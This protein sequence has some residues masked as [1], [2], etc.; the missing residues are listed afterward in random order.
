MKTQKISESGLIG[1]DGRLRIPMD[2]VNAW[3]AEHKG[4]RVVIRFEAAAPVQVNCNWHIIS[5]TLFRPSKRPFWKPAN[6]RPKNR[7]ICGCANNAGRV[8]TIMADCWKPGKYQT[9]LF[10]FLG[11]VETVCRRK[12]FRVY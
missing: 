2:R 1:T 9:R 5:I 6:A 12:P 11:M 7:L 4:E 10:R 8:I 3:C